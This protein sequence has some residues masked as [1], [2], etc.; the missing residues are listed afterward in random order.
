MAPP[1]AIFKILAAEK[2]WNP[3]KYEFPCYTYNIRYKDFWCY[4]VYDCETTS[5]AINRQTQTV[6]KSYI[7]VFMTKSDANGDS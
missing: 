3:Q 5:A 1:R 2:G 7:Y 6:V 4:T